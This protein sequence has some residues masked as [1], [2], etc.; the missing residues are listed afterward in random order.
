MDLGNFGSS[1]TLLISIPQGIATALSASMLPSI[2]ASYTEDD[3]DSI[4]SKKG[5]NLHVENKND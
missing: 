4:Y 2:V 1:Y 3:Y 5:V